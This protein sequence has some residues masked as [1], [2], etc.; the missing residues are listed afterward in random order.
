MS[1]AAAVGGVTSA[2]MG[3]GSTGGPAG[4]GA[5]SVASGSAGTQPQTAGTAAQGTGAAATDWTT[6]L[7]DEHRGFIQN[8]QFKS[9]ADL[10]ESYFNLEK[11]HSA[12]PERTVLIPKEE[13]DEAAWNAA[14]DKFGR[15]V[16]PE[17]YGLETPKEGGNPEFTKWAAENFHRLG[18]N[19]KQ[20]KGLLD[21]F[22]G[23]AQA[24]AEGSKQ[25]LVKATQDAEASL[26]KEWGAA[27]EENRT[28]AR[29]A[30]KQF[31]LDLAV[32]DKIESGAGAV[33]AIKFL[34]TI[35]KRLG[36]A[37]FVSGQ[38]ASANGNG[39]LEP[40]AAKAQIN[41]L[42]Q[43]KG[44]QDKIR[45]RDSDALSKWQRLNQWAAPDPS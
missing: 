23:Q 19:E 6:G 24:R 33:G 14:Y 38:G 36:E 18:L 16:N 34:N 22:H 29:Q 15:P 12:G 26:K 39:P 7:R 31:G 27:Y 41:Q 28:V 3:A 43:D 32:L 11:L 21:A 35:G 4:S 37:S 8:K 20:A 5:N 40:A 13:S 44:F 1:T 9:P 17:G 25:A 10:A 30:A 45:N 2:G 42:M